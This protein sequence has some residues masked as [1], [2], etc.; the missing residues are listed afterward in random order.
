MPKQPKSL[1][2]KLISKAFALKKQLALSDS[3]FNALKNT[4]TQVSSIR[5]MDNTHLRAFVSELE[6]LL[7]Q[8]DIAK[9]ATMRRLSSGQRAKILRLWL[10]VLQRRPLDLNSFLAKMTGKLDLRWLTASE[11]YN[12]IEAISAIIERRKYE[13][14]AR[15]YP[16]GDDYDARTRHHKTA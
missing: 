7:P 3:E 12:V 1:R 9:P 15:G 14:D 11:A 6:K 10:G 2:N 5:L 13:T 16:I 4:A 8:N